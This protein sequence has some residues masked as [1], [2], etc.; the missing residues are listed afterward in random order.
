MGW[1]KDIPHQNPD[2]KPQDA[3]WISNVRYSEQDEWK[4]M[5]RMLSY[6]IAQMV[7]L[8]DW[9]SVSVFCD[10]FAKWAENWTVWWIINQLCVTF[11]GNSFCKSFFSYA[12]TTLLFWL[13]CPEC[14][15]GGAMKRLAHLSSHPITNSLWAPCWAVFISISHQGLVWFGITFHILDMKSVAWKGFPVI[16]Q[17]HALK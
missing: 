12:Y 5:F 6:F 7:A 16:T 9:I 14:V 13:I 4:I 1:P 10:W 2:N 15:W 3:L 8:T 11:I 17:T